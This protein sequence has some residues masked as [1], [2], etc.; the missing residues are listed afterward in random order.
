MLIYLFIKSGGL[1]KADLLSKIQK[2]HL[3]LFSEG[4]CVSIFPRGGCIYEEPA[5]I[6]N[7][8]TG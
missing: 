3:K 8:R 5:W 4:E 2:T 1:F 6:E 7:E